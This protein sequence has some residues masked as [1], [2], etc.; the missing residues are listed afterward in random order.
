M[1][2][3]T[4]TVVTALRCTLAGVDEVV[5]AE[6]GGAEGALD[7]GVE[8]DKATVDAGDDGEH[9]GTAIVRRFR[10]VSEA[11]AASSKCRTANWF[12]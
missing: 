8:A 3:T 4:G 2:R 1:F 6:D 12:D 5:P 10:F 7:E 9:P 11:I